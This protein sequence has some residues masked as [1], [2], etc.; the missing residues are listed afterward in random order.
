VGFAAIRPN[1]RP[2]GGFLVLLPLPVLPA[3]WLE[4]EVASLFFL[5]FLPFFAGAE[6]VS[7]LP[8]LCAL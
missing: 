6:L 7:L 1:Q 3:P 8:W 5:F 4:P 2:V